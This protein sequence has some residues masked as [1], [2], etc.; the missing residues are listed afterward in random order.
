MKWLDIAKSL[1]GTREIPGPKHNPTILDWCKRLGARVLGIAITTD[2]VAWCGT[3]AAWCVTQAGLTPPKI[4]S[5]ASAWE[6]WEANLRA[7]RLAPGAV[8]VFRR[9]GGGHIGFYVG[10][11]RDCYHVLGGNQGNAVNITRIEK[12]RCVA[13]RWPRSLPVEGRP[14]WLTATGSI[15]KNEA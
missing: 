5:R 14:V 13:R 2:E 8:L 7:D 3:F 10:E 9:S 1:I 11:D 4:A 6:T 15:S 12:S